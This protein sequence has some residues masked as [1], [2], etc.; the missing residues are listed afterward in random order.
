M[1]LRGDLVEKPRFL[2]SWQPAV[3]LYL[4]VIVSVTGTLT[5][6]LLTGCGDKSGKSGKSQAVQPGKYIITNIY[7]GSLL[8]DVTAPEMILEDQVA[9][10]EIRDSENI[11]FVANGRY[12]NAT[13]TQDGDTISV[14]EYEKVIFTLIVRGDQLILYLESN[15]LTMVFTK[16]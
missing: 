16:E 4:L 6:S 2:R 14:Y 13:Y 9:Y 8:D 15:N 10:F 5:L 7:E 12:M 11:K 3:L 1:T